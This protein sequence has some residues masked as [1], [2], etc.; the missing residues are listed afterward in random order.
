MGELL[1]TTTE[2]DRRVAATDGCA[3]LPSAAEFRNALCGAAVLI[4]RHVSGNSSRNADV[5]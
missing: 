2:S 3:I 5:V 4:S 1:L